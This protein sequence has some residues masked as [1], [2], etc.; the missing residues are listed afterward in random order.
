MNDKPASVAKFFREN[1][2][3]LILKRTMLFRTLKALSKNIRINSINGY[4]YFGT[5]LTNALN[6]NVN[7]DKVYKQDSARLRLLKYL[8]TNK[9]PY[10]A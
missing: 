3:I 8:R 10:A 7:F 5:Y 2:H 1:E 9:T 6:F 4:K